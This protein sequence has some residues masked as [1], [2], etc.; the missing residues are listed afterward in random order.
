MILV[1]KYRKLLGLRRFATEELGINQPGERDV[2]IP[3]EAQICLVLMGDFL[4]KR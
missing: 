3:V 1:R 4:V 2:S